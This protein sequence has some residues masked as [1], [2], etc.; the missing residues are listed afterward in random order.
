MSDNRKEM[1]VFPGRRPRFHPPRP[2]GL[3]V[4]TVMLV[5]VGASA[6]SGSTEPNRPPERRGTILGQTLQPGESSTFDIADF[7]NDPDGDRLTYTA[8][9]SYAGQATASMSGSELTISAVAEGDPSVTVTATDPGGLFAVQSTNVYV[10]LPNRAPEAVGNIPSVSVQEESPVE[11]DVVWY[12]TDPDGDRLTYTAVA[13][14]AGVAAVAVAG[15]L[16]RFTAVTSGVTTVTVSATDP[17]G[18]SADH[19]IQVQSAAGPPGFRDDF[20]SDA[21]VGWQIAQAVAEVSEGVLRLTN[22]GSGMPG[23]AVRTPGRTL[24][25][26]QTDLRLGRV[27]EDAV[28]RAVFHN[29][30]TEIPTFAVEIGSGVAID[31]RDTN[32]RF[33]I[34][35]QGAPGWEPVFFANSDLIADSTGQFTEINV[36]FRELRIAVTAGSDTL[37]FE[38]LGRQGV[39]AALGFLTGVE[40][41]AV[42]LGGASERTVLFDWIEVTGTPVAGGPAASDRPRP[43]S[44]V[45][46]GVA[47]EAGVVSRAPASA[48]T[49]PR[50]GAAPRIRS[51]MWPLPGSRD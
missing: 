20:D 39:P 44:P 35:P 26:W 41:W 9:S 50:P 48:A 1:T 38:D 47:D 10:R 15:S 49:P 36:A 46:R 29:S 14:D 19:E 31:G 22:A 43:R 4:A 11:L 13:N 42:P 12:F 25:N 3:G 17:G 2:R 8:E 33:L 28:V 27:H 21:L 23:R 18:L 6:C 24:A 32:L 40:L 37:Y 5:I 30:T 16:V 45:A 51:G 7:F 34:L